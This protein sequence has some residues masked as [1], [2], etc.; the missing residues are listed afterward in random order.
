MG[1]RVAGGGRTL[2]R[3]ARGAARAGSSRGRAARAAA[4][5]S[6]ALGAGDVPGS[7]L[8]P[9]AAPAR[10]LSAG[11]TMLAGRLRDEL[12]GKRYG[13]TRDGAQAPLRAIR[14][15]GCG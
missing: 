15:R 4:P 13:L 14:R 11:C 10:A 12:G 8:P 2:L 9:A 7:V 3:C 1:G 5:R 6:R